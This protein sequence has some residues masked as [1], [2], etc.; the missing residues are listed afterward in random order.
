MYKESE[1]ENSDTRTAL[2]AVPLE[3][4]KTILWPYRMRCGSINTHKKTHTHT[5]THPHPHPHT[6]RVKTHTR[7]CTRHHITTLMCK[8]TLKKNVWH[9]T[10]QCMWA[11]KRI[12][13]RFS[14]GFSNRFSQLVLS[15]ALAQRH[16]LHLADGGEDYL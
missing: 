3:L 10:V 16:T 5:C 7:T 14:Y 4:K 6:T 12:G 11:L 15:L 13:N 1:K 9:H 8:P 2:E